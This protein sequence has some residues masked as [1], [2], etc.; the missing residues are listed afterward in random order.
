MGGDVYTKPRLSVDQVRSWLALH[1]GMDASDVRPLDGG[2]WSQAFV[3][4]SDK[5]ERVLRLAEDGEGFAIDAKAYG[6]FG[7]SLPIPQVYEHGEATG[8]EAPN[9]GVPLQYAISRYHEGVFLERVSVDY[10]AAAVRSL[11][12]LL[13]ALR[14]VPTQ[15]DESVVWYAPGQVTWHEYMQERLTN[16]KVCEG[17]EIRDAASIATACQAKALD[18]LSQCPERRDLVH[19]DLFHQNVLLDSSAQTVT[20][21]FSW[22]CSALGDFLYD[23]AW[24]TFWGRWYEGYSAGDLQAQLL[25]SDTLTPDMLDNAQARILC[26]QLQIAISHIDWYIWVGDAVWLERVLQVARQLLAQA[27][28]SDSERR[29]L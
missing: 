22:K 8:L 28:G 16:V 5:E 10:A 11:Q 2:F 9:S 21:I 27:R 1:Q 15:A 13:A 7:S 29:G 19:C 25:A 17:S 6:R 12:E 18:L 26:Y 24:C 3:F 4:R 20:G 23:V 14:A